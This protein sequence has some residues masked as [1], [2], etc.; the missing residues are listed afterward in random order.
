MRTLP[1]ASPAS[2]RSLR[3]GRTAP[4]GVGTRARTLSTVAL[5]PLEIASGVHVW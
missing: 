4:G 1:E 5:T 3:C 2:A